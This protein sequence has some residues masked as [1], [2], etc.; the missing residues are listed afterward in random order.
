M[1]DPR[2]V[3]LA[4]ILVNYSVGV[5][6]GDWVLINADTLALPLATEVVRHVLKAGGN[7]NIL[8][9]DDSL[10]EVILEESTEDQLVWVS[11]ID[12]LL[13]NDIDAWISLR[14]SKNTRALTAIDPNKQRTRQKARRELMDTYMQ[15]SATGD[16]RWVTTNYPCHAFAQEADMSLKDF[17]DFVFKATFADQPDPIKAW[18][19]VHNEQQRLI[20]WLKGKKDVVVRG[21]NADLSLSIEDRIFINSDG[22]HNM[23]SGEIFTGP[24]ENSVKGWVKF[25]YPAVNAGR[26]VEGVELEFN[27]GKVVQAKARKNEAYLIS[28]LDSDEGARYLGEFAIGTN[29]GIQKFTKNILYDEKIGGSFHMAVGAGY[30][31]TGS[32]NKSSIHW[33]FICDIRADSQ[34]L[35][36][37]ELFYKDGKFTV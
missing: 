24:V 20:D 32:L 17:E 19:D 5:N 4:K 2:I 26:E 3:N 12:K 27:D 37:G 15:R 25:T 14:A 13:I 8:L 29:Y 35:V 34:I 6:P 9:N 33:D 36:D 31:E 11:P 7:P 22:H 21:P 23:P 30:P 28:M 18:T 16:L 1:L 10:Q